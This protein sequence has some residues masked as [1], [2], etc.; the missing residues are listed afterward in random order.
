M[1]TSYCNE[2]WEYRA[3][4]NG[5]GVVSGVIVR[6]GDVA[7]IGPTLTE[8]IE[9][10]AFT[11][12]EWWATRM[13]ERP[14]ILGRTGSNLILSDDSD[15]LRFTLELPPTQRGRDT[16]YE[17]E[18]GHLLGASVE[19]GDVKASYK[20]NRRMVRKSTAVRFS[21]VDKPAYPE[22]LLKVDRWED[23]AESGL[24]VRRFR[25]VS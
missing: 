10:G 17:L 6:Y 2:E 12:G 21:L 9:R 16:A 24:L 13:H 7:K 19:L 23:W 20:G 5:L 15:A 1:Q 3:D 8:Q 11:M 22:S 14:A 4:D 18:H 25:K